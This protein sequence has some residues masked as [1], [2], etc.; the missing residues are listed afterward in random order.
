MKCHFISK[1]NIE[2]KYHP[3][4]NSNFCHLRSHHNSDEDYTNIINTMKEQFKLS[5]LKLNNFKI[6]DITPDGACAF[7]CMVRALYDVKKKYQITFR[8]ESDYT[9]KLM[10]IIGENHKL[11]YNIETALAILMQQIIREWI[12]D[13]KNHIVENMDC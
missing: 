3:I 5:T 10:Q 8:H 7:R 4:G 12:M 13:N 6:W 2:C 9:D 11:N 1:K